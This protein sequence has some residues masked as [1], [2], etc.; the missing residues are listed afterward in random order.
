MLIYDITYGMGLSY[1]SRP[2]L[3]FQIQMPIVFYKA[4][5][6]LSV[7]KNLAI[8]RTYMVLLCSEASYVSKEGLFEA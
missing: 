1:L 8:C 2:F 3:P 6:F 5:C 7:A 4:V